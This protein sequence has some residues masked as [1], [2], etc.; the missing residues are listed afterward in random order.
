MGGLWSK[1]MCQKRL[2]FSSG[3][4]RGTVRDRLLQERVDFFYVF[5][6]VDGDCVLV[7]TARRAQ[8][9]V[10]G[11]LGG[12]RDTRPGRMGMFMML[13]N[14]YLRAWLLWSSWEISRRDILRSSGWTGRYFGGRL[15]GWR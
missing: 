5:G 15:R 2:C 13:Q 14:F 7:A 12:D 1:F 8:F 10:Q 4:G 9:C 6:H 3:S 11:D